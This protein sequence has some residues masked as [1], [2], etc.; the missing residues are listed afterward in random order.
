MI[1]DARIHDMRGKIPNDKRSHGKIYLENTQMAAGF[2]FKQ[3]E[4]SGICAQETAQMRAI[5]HKYVKHHMIFLPM[6]AQNHWFVS[7]VNSKLRRI[8]VLNSHKPKICRYR[9]SSKKHG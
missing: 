3:R 5:A 2:Q 6:S 1:V 8:H 7:V 4:K 9:A